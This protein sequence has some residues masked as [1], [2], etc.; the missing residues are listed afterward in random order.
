MIEL[1]GLVFLGIWAAG[2]ARQS[3]KNQYLWSL[4]PIGLYLTIYLI[5]YLILNLAFS[6]ELSPL[7]TPP[8]YVVI[9]MIIR[10][11]VIPISFIVSKLILDKL[12]KRVD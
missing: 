8:N 9:E 10:I 4:V 6:I 5:I 12:L 3:G 2:K 7:G 1:V 11:G